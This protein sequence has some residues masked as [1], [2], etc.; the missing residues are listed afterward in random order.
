MDSNYENIKK[1]IELLELPQDKPL[2]LE[3]IKQQYRLLFKKYHPDLTEFKD[4]KRLKK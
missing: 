2:T 1:Y 3:T 4:E